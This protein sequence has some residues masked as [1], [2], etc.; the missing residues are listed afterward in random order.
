MTRTPK[1]CEN[2]DKVKG[3]LGKK[4]SKGAENVLG[5]HRKLRK[6]FTATGQKPNG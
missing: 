5:V 4:S 6:K 2:E 1:S 3:G